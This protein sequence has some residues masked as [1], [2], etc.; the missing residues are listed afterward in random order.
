MKENI[1]GILGI[2]FGNVKDVFENGVEVWGV[3]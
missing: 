3:L 1:I 2:L